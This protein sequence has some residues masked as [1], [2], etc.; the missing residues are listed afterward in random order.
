MALRNAFAYG[1]W[2]LLIIEMETKRKPLGRT[3]YK[4]LQNQALE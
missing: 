3:F 1:I 4:D 2:V